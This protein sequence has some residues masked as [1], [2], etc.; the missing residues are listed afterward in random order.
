MDLS[1]FIHVVDPTKVRVIE[2]ERAEGEK[3]LLESIN[4][5]AEYVTAERPRRQRKKRPAVMD[6]KGSSHPPKKLR[7][8]HRT[9]SGAATGGK[10]P[11]VL[12]ELLASSILSVEVVVKVVATLPLI[13]SLISATPEREGGDLTDSVVGPNLRTIGLSER[14]V[15]S[16]DSSHHSSTNASRADVDS[17]IRSAVLL[18]VM[19]EAVIT[20][21]DVSVPSIPVLETV[22][23]LLLRFMLLCFMTLTSQR[24]RD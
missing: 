9:S 2:R 17:I 12:K 22:P 1:A 5:A 24:Q 8:D 6:A 16:S 4:I 13:T 19:T 10:S 3:K 23:R 20:S 15:I 7:G 21:Y 14:F 18:L 11:S